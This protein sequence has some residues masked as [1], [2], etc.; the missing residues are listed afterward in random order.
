MADCLRRLPRARA[1][2]TLLLALLLIA[3]SSRAGTAS[4]SV[5]DPGLV[6]V[7][8]AH[9]RIRLD[10]RYATTNN[11]TGRKVYPCAKAYL[12]RTTAAK[13]ARAEDDLEQQGLG[14]KVYDAYRPLAVQKIFWELVPDENYVAN[15]A[16]GSRHNR[17]GAVDVTLVRLDTGAELPMPSGYD[18]FSAKAHYAYTNLAANV[19]S[20][21]ALLRATMTRC[22]F[23]P[24][25]TEW[26]HFDDTNWPAF[27]LLDVGLDQLP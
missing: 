19:I 2:G 17:G 24:M 6:A 15:P 22:G 10:I 4:N 11:F 18:D 13:L 26:W 9:A 21:R 12:R 23:V 7:T 3:G 8:A 5:P 14:L 20:N 16:Q 27:E 1:R 25:E